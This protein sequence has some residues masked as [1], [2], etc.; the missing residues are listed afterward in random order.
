MVFLSGRCKGG[1]RDGHG[2]RRHRGADA[3]QARRQQRGQAAGHR[4][5]AQRA[6]QRRPGALEQIDLQRPG[7]VVRPR[8]PHPHQQTQRR[9]RGFARG[10]LRPAHEHRALRRTGQHLQAAQLLG[11]GLR[12]PGHQHARRAGL[13]QLFGGPQAF[14]RG[15]GLQP[16][17]AAFVDAVGPQA[18]GV[19]RVRRAD[20]QHRGGG[21]RTG[22]ATGGAQRAQQRREQAPC[23]RAGLGAEQ[24]G[25]ALAGPAAAG[26]LGVERGKAAG[27]GGRGRAAELVAPPDGG[28]H[29]RRQRHRGGRFRDRNGRGRKGRLPARNGLHG[30]PMIAP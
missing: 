10:G 26:Q 14:G 5:Q 11:P 25:Q 15:V 22:A 17:Q 23:Q 2:G 18:G 3:A 20:Q 8:C 29:G 16:D 27:P 28:G 9:G 6:R 13:E 12:Q 21:C 30:G 24:F 4:R 7:A 1:Q 19:R